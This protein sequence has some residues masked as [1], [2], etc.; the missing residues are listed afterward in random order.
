MGIRELQAAFNEVASP[1]AT[2]LKALLDYKRGSGT[3]WQLIVFSGSYADGTPFVI[4]SEAQ[5]PGSNLILASRETAT[6][7]LQQKRTPAI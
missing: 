1:D 6:A 3:E 4:Q 5:R 2:C 7:L